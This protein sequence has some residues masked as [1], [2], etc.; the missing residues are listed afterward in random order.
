[1]DRQ[2]GA[3]TLR[4]T[5]VITAICNIY[6]NSEKKLELFKETFPSVYPVSDNWL[7]NIRGKNRNEA[8]DFIST[9]FSDAEA[10]CIFYTNLDR[11]NW[12]RAT[13][14]M[15]QDSRYEYIYVFLEDHF[16]L[17]PLT[18]FQNVIEDMK[19]C[20]IDYFQYSFFNIGLSVQS[21]EALYPDYSEYFY[22]FKVDQEKFKF[23]KQNN[24]HFYPYSLAGICSKKYFKNLLT[25]ERRRLVRVPSLIQILMENI[26]FIYPRN[27]NFWFAINR[28]ASRLG[29]RFVIYPPETPFNLEKSLFDCDS[30]LLPMTV[31]GLREELFANWDDDNKLSNSSLI[32]RG[33]YPSSLRYQKHDDVSPIGGKDYTLYN[34]ECSSHQYIPDVQRVKN[35]PLK[36]ILVKVGELKIYSERETY[37]LLKGQSI[38]L[39]AN[40][41]HTLKAVEDC[42]YYVCIENNGID[43][44]A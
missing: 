18:H 14:T 32:K 37:V 42:V 33:L 36:Y 3:R 35:I 17:K 12:A 8:I 43:L 34:G 28:Y 7:L 5:L 40:G 41:H 21:S 23:L 30:S 22:Y 19:E 25:I 24:R 15:L 1:M 9:S 2:T 31:G 10:N 29:L 11:N 4:K 26:I 38:W 6:I 39:Y 44:E 20:Q 13:S 16:L 27:R